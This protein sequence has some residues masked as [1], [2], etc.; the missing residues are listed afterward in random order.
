MENKEKQPPITNRFLLAL[1]VIVL[2]FSALSFDLTLPSFKPYWQSLR[3]SLA[4]RMPTKEITIQQKV[5]SEESAVIEVVEKVS[6]AVVSIVA[7]QVVFNPF[8]GPA[9]EESGIGTGFIIESGGKIVTNRHVVSA[10]SARYRVVLRDGA[11]YEVAEIQRDPFLDLAILKIE[12]RDLPT[13]ELGDSDNLKVGQTVVAIGNALGRFTNT[14]T[15]GVVSGIGRGITAS[16]GF[17]Q[18][19]VLDDVIQTDAA[20]NPGNSGGPLLNLS[21]EV[22]GINV[23]ATEGADNIGFSIPVNAL[24]SV[25]EGYRARGRIVRPFLGVEYVII[26]EDLSVLRKLP[27]GAFIQ[28]V[29][30]GTPAAE[31][32]LKAGDIIVKVDGKEINE[33]NTLAKVIRAHQVGDELKLTIDRNGQVLTLEIT[34]SEAPTE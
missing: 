6:P 11:D 34:L 26:T 20:L 19:E 27:Q 2:L 31:A 7:R 21:G 23:A 1:V 12:A 5:V 25:L 4:E 8:T 16:S 30:E 9:S 33:S 14:V 13:V 24:K 3:D 29:V 10:D 18:S 28:R 15:V 17:G 32:G 22:V